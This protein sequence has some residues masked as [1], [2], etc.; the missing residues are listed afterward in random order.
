MRPWPAPSLTQAVQGSGLVFWLQNPVTLG[1]E[2]PSEMAF[3]VSTGL[4]CSR[5]GVV[6]GPQPS[7]S[8]LTEGC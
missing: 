3:H 8:E 7:C 2:E 1:E 5:A 6:T 4:S